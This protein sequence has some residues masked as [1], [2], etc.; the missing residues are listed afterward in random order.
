MEISAT[1]LWHVRNRGRIPIMGRDYSALAAGSNITP[2]RL[3]FPSHDHHSAPNL[4]SISSSLSCVLTAQKSALPSRP[5][6]LGQ[7][8]CISSMANYR[9]TKRQPI[10]GNVRSSS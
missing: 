4:I 1:L 8:V 9:L 6:I 7:Y 2:Y 3:T 10:R 5:T